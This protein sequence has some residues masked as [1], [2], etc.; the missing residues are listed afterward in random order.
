VPMH[1]PPDRE[2]DKDQP[3]Y[4]ADPNGSALTVITAAVE[5]KPTPKENEEQ[6]DDQN[7]FHYLVQRIRRIQTGAKKRPPEPRVAACFAC[8]LG[9]EYRS[10]MRRRCR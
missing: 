5:P 10:W 2:D 1:Q 7:Q 6:Q 8:R 9:S 3:E 4:A